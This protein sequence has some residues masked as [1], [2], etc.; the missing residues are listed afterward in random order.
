VDFDSYLK[1]Y[2]AHPQPP[3]RFA[4]VGLHGLTLYFADFAEAVAY[5]EQV[6]G[7]PAY[8]EGEDTRGWMVGNT[9]LTLLH[10]T[11][12][13]PQNVE[14]LFV[15]QT[16]QEAERLQAAFVAAGG[17]GSAASDQ[18]MYQPVLHCPVRNPFG[19]NILI[20]AELPG[21]RPSS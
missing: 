16:P 9:W 8:I 17:V 3:S 5:Y 21:G 4:F 10:G 18:L 19:T 12:G 6:L 13:T 11:S 1:S 14:L 20:I 15:M 7:P 2:F